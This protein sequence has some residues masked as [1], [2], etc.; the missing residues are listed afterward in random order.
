MEKTTLQVTF[1]EEKLEPLRFYM[2][3][4][5]LTVED[6]LQTFMDCLYEKYVPVATRRYL[7]RN[8]EPVKKQKKKQDEGQKRGGMADEEKAAQSKNHRAKRQI[9]KGQST[10]QQIGVTNLLSEEESQEEQESLEKET[11]GMMLSM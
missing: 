5:E 2:T 3:E 10:D 11:Q 9:E 4:K 7:D 6:E 8:D 1:P